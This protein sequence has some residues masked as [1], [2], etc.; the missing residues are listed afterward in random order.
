MNEKILQIFRSKNIWLT[1]NIAKAAVETHAKNL[2]PDSTIATVRDGEPIVARYYDK[3]ISYTFS[4]S[5]NALA[6]NPYAGTNSADHTWVDGFDSFDV[7]PNTASYDS[8]AYIRVGSASSWSYYELTASPTTFPPITET[9]GISSIFGIVFDRDITVDGNTTIHKTY[10]EWF[11]SSDAAQAALD[12][13]TYSDISDDGTGFVSGVRQNNGLIEVLHG[14]IEGSGAID[15]TNSPYEYVLMTTQTDPATI[16]GSGWEWQDTI[17]DTGVALPSTVTTSSSKYYRVGTSPNFTYYELKR[18]SVVSLDIDDD[19]NVLAQG[20]VVKWNFL[21]EEPVGV[22][23]D[24]SNTGT[25][26]PS[27]TSVNVSYYR[28]GVNPDFTYYEKTTSSNDSGLSANLALRSLSPSEISALGNNV[29]TAYKLVGNADGS[30]TQ[31]G[32]IIKI[33]KDQSLY[34]VYLGHVDDTLT[35]PTSPTVISGT[36]NDALCFIYEINDGTYEL[37]AID[38]ESFLTETEF[39]DG[40]E[41]V[42]GT[43][44][45]KQ[46]SEEP[47]GVTWVEGTNSGAA[48]PSTV[49]QSSPEY[50]RVVSGSDPNF[51]YTYYKLSSNG[52]VRVKLSSTGGLEFK[53]EGAGVNQSVGININE[54]NAYAVPV[55]SGTGELTR[56]LLYQWVESGAIV[57]NEHVIYTA[58]DHYAASGVDLNIYEPTQISY[59]YTRTE[60]ATYITGGSDT[61]YTNGTV[62][63]ANNKHYIPTGVVFM[64]YYDSGANTGDYMKETIL[65]TT[66]N[67]LEANLQVLEQIAIDKVQNSFVTNGKTYQ[68]NPQTGLMEAVVTGNDIPIADND[69]EVPTVTELGRIPTSGDAPGLYSYNGNIYIWDGTTATPWDI[70]ENTTVSDAISVLN[71]LSYNLDMG[72]YYISN[73]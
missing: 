41:I 7:K 24:S 6:S 27:A 57:D 37:V 55:A 11:D 48:L 58:T 34:S 29:K 17:A 60:P 36:G 50:Y 19:S 35:S 32:E 16:S 4:Y 2:H 8:A 73:N 13:L 67:G 43:Y 25:T 18:K 70:D 26:L 61:Y 51:T 40:L 68:Y 21:S 66:A 72:Q 5:V 53:N 23:W 56:V 39:K 30:E 64:K 65:N 9:V 52:E 59:L 45:Y 44:E 71:Y 3:G 38:I 14:T 12:H 10:I 54:D 63:D 31:L 1:K 47:S 22:T 46:I 28:V 33:Y 49:T 15:V 62:T 69:N 42:H 20:P